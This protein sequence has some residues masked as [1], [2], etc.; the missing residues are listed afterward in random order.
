M[1]LREKIQSRDEVIISRSADPVSGKV[2]PEDAPEP[3]ATK[4]GHEHF[5]LV[6]RISSTK[7]WCMSQVDLSLGSHLVL[8]QDPLSRRATDSA[9][10]F[11]SEV[12]PSLGLD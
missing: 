4:S 7:A 1:R 2:M 12:E 3:R 9:T 6:R 10:S 8:D 5:S 11:S